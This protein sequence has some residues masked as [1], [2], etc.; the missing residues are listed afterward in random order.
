VEEIVPLFT[1]VLLLSGGSTLA[2]GPKASTLTS[3]YL[4]TAFN[5]PMT[6]RR[7]AGRYQ[8]AIGRKRGSFAV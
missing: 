5:A 8:L 7:H 1:H 4:S 2:S 6:L 3:R